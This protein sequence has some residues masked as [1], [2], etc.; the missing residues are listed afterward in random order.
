MART[1]AIKLVKALPDAVDVTLVDFDTQVRGARFSQNDFPRMVERIRGRKADGETALY[2]A[3]GTYLDSASA[4]DGR[5]VVVVYTDG[6]DNRSS[7]NYAET[8]TL[9]KASDV[10]MYTVGFLS[11]LVSYRQL[12]ARARLQRLTTPTGGQAFAPGSLKDIEQAYDKIVAD[13]K[14]Q[15]TLG[16]VSTNAG[17]DGKWRKVDVR[18][19]RPGLKTRARQ[20]YFA[21]Y[22]KSP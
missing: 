19:T 18:V 22:R 10:T 2:D 5:K 15:Y 8:M 6:E 4:Q 21:P 12:D 13:I 3:L 9:L 7:L 11:H 16:Y 17:T 20:G 1:A 14:A